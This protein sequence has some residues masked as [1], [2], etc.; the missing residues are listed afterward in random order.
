[1][2][3]KKAIVEVYEDTSKKSYNIFTV[4]IKPEGENRYAIHSLGKKSR[5]PYSFN[6]FSH[7]VHEDA[8]LGYEEYML[9]ELKLVKRTRLGKNL[10]E[11]IEE[12]I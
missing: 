5:G 4:A 8:F 9:E 12:L 1:M 6:Q 2:K 7:Y 3:Y 10:K 11:G